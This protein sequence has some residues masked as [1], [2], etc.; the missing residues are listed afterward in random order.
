L[1]FIYKVTFNDLL[2]TNSNFYF[3]NASSTP[4]TSSFSLP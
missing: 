3:R 2:S 4:P 1:N